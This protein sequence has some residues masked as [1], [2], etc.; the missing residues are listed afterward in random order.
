MRRA[1]DEVIASQQ[2]MLDRH[3]KASEGLDNARLAA[4][5]QRQLAD[6]LDWL[7]RQANFSVL[8]VD[9]HYVIEDPR[10]VVQRLN[11]FLGYCLDTN[12][13]LQ[14]PDASLYRQRRNAV[15]VATATV[16][17]Q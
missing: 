11:D 4:I 12:A 6:A 17:R 1:L 14:V 13:M 7:A 2:V 3:G 5:Y 15:S 10:H 8:S 16:D 9:Y